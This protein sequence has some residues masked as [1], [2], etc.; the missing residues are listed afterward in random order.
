MEA[1]GLVE[2]SCPNQEIFKIRYQREAE[3]YSEIGKGM[4]DIGASAF[5]L[6]KVRLGS[7]T[8]LNS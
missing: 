5:S 2:F 3:D 7:G 6:N 4:G 1:M 8:S